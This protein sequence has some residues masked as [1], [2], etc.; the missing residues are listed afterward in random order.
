MRKWYALT[1]EQHTEWRGPLYTTMVGP[2]R[3]QGTKQKGKKRQGVRKGRRMKWIEHRNA[4][5]A[6]YT[7]RERERELQRVREWEWERASLILESSKWNEVQ[8]KEQRKE[9]IQTGHLQCMTLLGL[10]DGKGFL[11]KLS[12]WCGRT[13][14]RR[15][16]ERE[17]ERER[18]QQTEYN[19]LKACNKQ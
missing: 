13:G 14:K 17:R 11:R 4:K 9:T 7:Q 16:R 19:T 6:H 1:Q 12:F 2:L 3:E 15:Q 18:D 10:L 8:E 5:M